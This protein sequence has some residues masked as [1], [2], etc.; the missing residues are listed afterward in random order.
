MLAKR[1][2][3]VVLWCDVGVG[4]AELMG[5]RETATATATTTTVVITHYHYHITIAALLLIYMVT[6][7]V[8]DGFVTVSSVA[9]RKRW[10]VIYCVFWGCRYLLISIP[11]TFVSVSGVPSQLSTCRSPS[12]SFVAV[13]LKV[14]FYGFRLYDEMQNIE[15]PL[16]YPNGNHW[17]LLVLGVKRF[18]LRIYSLKSMLMCCLVVSCRIHWWWEHD[19]VVKTF[20][21]TNLLTSQT[22]QMPANTQRPVLGI[23]CNGSF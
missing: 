6:S 4:N 13:A 19:R 15:S 9:V 12:L 16:L 18:S 11:S 1:R 17:L 3:V 7:G 21:V 5:H 10:W 8:T 2:V 23:L 20:N 22:Q 14:G